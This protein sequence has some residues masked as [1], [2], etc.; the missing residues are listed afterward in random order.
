MAV[1]GVTALGVACAAGVIKDGQDARLRRLGLDEVA[2]DLIVEE[3]DRLPG[4]AF[5]RILV[6]LG[7]QRKL[8]E[9]LLQLLVD[10]V[11]AHL[12]EAVLLEDLKLLIDLIILLMCERRYQ[13]SN[14]PL[15]KL[16]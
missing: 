8:N 16:N 1:D 13:R 7:T 4:D 11:D 6:L 15:L 10:I 3:W 2:D 12:L 14:S 5:G 9:D